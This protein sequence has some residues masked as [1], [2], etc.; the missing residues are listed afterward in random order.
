MPVHLAARTGNPLKVVFHRNGHEVETRLCDNGEHAVRSLI[1]MAASVEVL[2][3]GD[4]F[5]VKSA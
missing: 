4:V 1:L 5:Q 3:D 2:K